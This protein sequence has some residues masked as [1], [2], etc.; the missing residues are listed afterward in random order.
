MVKIDEI[1]KKEN[2][3]KNISKMTDK[4]YLMET[5]TDETLSPHIHLA[6]LLLITIIVAV[7]IA[8]MGF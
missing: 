1:L 7:V 4:D 8:L 2:I 6:V 5:L 3:S